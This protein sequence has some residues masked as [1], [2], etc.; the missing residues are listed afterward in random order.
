[1]GTRTTPPVREPTH[2][3]S[4]RES[5]MRPGAALFAPLYSARR[6]L[7]RSVSIARHR[8]PHRLRAA[9]HDRPRRALLAPRRRDPL[10]AGGGGLKARGRGR[11]QP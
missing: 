7:M 6:F 1:V 3:G 9:P 11:H 5:L 4:K 10:R 2:T 8:R